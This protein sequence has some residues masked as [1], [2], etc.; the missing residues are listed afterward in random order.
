[1]MARS[2]TNGLKTRVFL[3]DDHPLIRRGLQAL[4]SLEPDMTVCGEADSAPAAL[5]GIPAARPD[6]VTVDLQLRSGS[7]LELIKQLRAQGLRLKVLVLT[8]RDEAIY[9]DHAL[10]AGAD[11]FV[12]KG[13]GGQ[14]VLEAIR[15]VARGRRFFSERRMEKMLDRWSGGAAPG[16][17]G[18]AGLSDREVQVLESMPFTMP[19]ARATRSSTARLATPNWRRWR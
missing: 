9:G 1:M 15:A 19:R 14:K 8:I 5:E 11:G 2:K 6:V 10:Q 17:S 13:E 7:G 4:L 16:G 12:G 18:A 3:V